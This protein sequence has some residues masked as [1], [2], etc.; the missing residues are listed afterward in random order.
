LKSAD[1]AEKDLF[2]SHRPLITIANLKIRTPPD[3]NYEIG[4]GLRN[5][6][7]GFAAVNKIGVTLQTVDSNGHQK[8]R[9]A[10]ADWNGS[11]EAG[12]LVDGNR[13]AS[14][15]IGREGYQLIRNGGLVLFVNFEVLSQDIF[16]NN[17]RQVFSFVFNPQASHFER[18]PSQ[19][20]QEAKNN[21]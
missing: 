11:I 14:E 8:T 19:W 20:S 1:T 6:G 12:E 2:A 15:I 18:A 13:V 7:K 10:S 4:F 21:E 9:F 17:I 5:S 3:G 16:H